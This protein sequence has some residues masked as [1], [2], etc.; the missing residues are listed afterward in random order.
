METPLPTTKVGTLRWVLRVYSA[1]FLLGF[2]FLEVFP[3][4]FGKSLGSHG[5]NNSIFR[6]LGWLIAIASICLYYLAQSANDPGIKRVIFLIFLVNLGLIGEDFSIYLNHLSNASLFLGDGI[7]NILTN[8]F[9]MQQ[10]LVKK[11]K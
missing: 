4:E 9:L 10:L 5:I 8:L 7:F 11:L 3:K 1:L 2:I 6:Y